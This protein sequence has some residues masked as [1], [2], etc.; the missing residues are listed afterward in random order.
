MLSENGVTFILENKR[1]E[2]DGISDHQYSTSNNEIEYLNQISYEHFFTDYLRKNK[3]CI[4][5]LKDIKMW[6][7]SLDW[8][9]DEKPNFDFL[10]EH[11]GG[12]F[13][14]INIMIYYIRH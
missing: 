8:I 5:F 7:S 12:I 2:D 4:I 14:N 3:P 13:F 6:R 11:F 9:A 1:S 10:E